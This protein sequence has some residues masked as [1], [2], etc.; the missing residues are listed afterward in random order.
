MLTTVDLTRD[1]LADAFN[2]PITYLRISVTDKCNLRCV[3]CMPESGLP[4]LRRDELLSYE[5]IVAIARAAARAGVRTIRLTGGEPLVR[6]DLHRLVAGISAIDG[7]E[8]IALSTNALLLEEQLDGLLAAGLRRVN[9]SLD[10][11]RAD[12]FERIARRPGLDAVLRGIDAAIAAKLGPVKL[13][14]VVMRGEND[15][16]IADF[17]ALTREREVFVRFIEV[18]PVH[19][20]LGL[21]RDA[22]VSSDEILARVAAVER[23]EP[24]AGPPGNGPARY[25]AYPGA[26]GAV[27]VISPLSHDY[28]ERCNRVRL[29]ADGRLRLCL[30]GDQHVD[31]RTPL[32]AGAGTEELAELLR[33]SM[34][35]KPERHHLRLGEA[36]SRMRAFSEIGG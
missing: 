8:D 9:V 31:L 2:R 34:S 12:R 11:L 13:N 15:D 36:S 21:Q 32:R 33:A 6:R 18:M 29:T 22:Y 19:E 30:F 1:L 35:I 14:C 20:N 23:I 16:E 3:Y 25:F 28:C 24:V 26:P 4:W 10:T 7:I 5:E 17:A 27:G